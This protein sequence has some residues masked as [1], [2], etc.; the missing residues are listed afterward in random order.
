[1]HSIR[2]K[3]HIPCGGANRSQSPSRSSPTKHLYMLH[4]VPEKIATLKSSLLRHATSSL[5]LLRVQFS[6]LIE[7]MLC[8]WAKYSPRL[9]PWFYF[10]SWVWTLVFHFDST[11]STVLLCRL[12]M[13]L[14]LCCTT[15]DFS[16]HISQPHLVLPILRWLCWSSNKI[17][18]LTK[19]Q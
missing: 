9:A 6:K 8:I 13:L 16:R 18:P 19:V 1:M 2:R 4:S 10:L 5:L 11:L 3:F 15:V 17:S 7:T 12:S 14:L